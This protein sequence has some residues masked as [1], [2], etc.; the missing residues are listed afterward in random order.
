MGKTPA[1]EM[2]R[3]LAETKKKLA[4]EAKKMKVK[5]DKG[6]GVK[7][8]KGAKQAI[9][10]DRL[11]MN[12]ARAGKTA[13]EIRLEE[14]KKKDVAAKRKMK[15][16]GLTEEEL[17]TGKKVVSKFGTYDPNADPKS[18]LCGYFKAGKCKQGLKCKFSHDM[19]L[20]VS[21]KKKDKKSMYADDRKDDTMDKWDQAKLEMV[22]KQKFKPRNAT[23]IV[24]KHFIDAIETKK[25]GWFWKCLG[26]DD[27]MYQHQL[28]PGFVLK[29]DLAAQKKE[30]DET[31]LV[32]RI[33]MERAKLD[34][35]KLTPVTPETFAAW[36]VKQKAK[37]LEE[38]K[39]VIKEKVRAHKK[40]RD[41]S[42]MSGRNLFTYNPSLFVDDIDAF[43]EFE[44]DEEKVIGDD[45]E[46]ET[47]TKQWEV[48][49]AQIDFEAK[50]AANE[51]LFLEDVELPPD[52]EVDAVTEGVASV[53]LDATAKATAEL[54]HITE[55]KDIVKLKVDPKKEIKKEVKKKLTKE[56]KL[57][58][59][60]A[61]AEAKIAAK[62]AKEK[63]D[64]KGPTVCKCT[65]T[66]MCPLCR[67]AMEEEEAA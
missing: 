50:L 2:A 20:D 24:C 19:N 44:D 62:L 32:E 61:K 33:E 42:G 15:K 49:Q 64:A 52:E 66:Y 11:R 37:K 27:C 23:T 36:K 21:H 12:A 31:T 3:K 5:E 67:K 38:E 1:Q 34:R 60:K 41:K 56:E 30:E 57:A 48:T 26:G 45:D 43:A 65:G 8:A 7:N 55:V 47:E 63:A 9:N 22:V 35:T 59:K 6:F 54:A 16:L 4:A 53:A 29:S 39:M 14:Q 10:V 58:E 51:K 13:E 17:L 18:I 46:K 28:P 40:G 25:Y